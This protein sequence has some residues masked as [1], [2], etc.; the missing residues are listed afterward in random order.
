ML[1][2]LYQKSELW[3]A[4]SWIF[5]YVIGGSLSD[6]ISEKMGAPKL[7]T[8]LF[9]AGLSAVAFVWL[10]KNDLFEK[11]GLCRSAIPARRLLYYLPLAA[12]ASC[13][14]WLG[15]RVNAPAG[16]AVAYVGSMLL[17]GFLEEIIFRGFLFKAMA[18]DGLRPAIIVS[19]VTFGM[20][21]IV[22]LVNGSGAQLLPNLC[23]VGYAIAFGFLFVLLFYKTG[24]LLACIAAHS[25]TNMLSV[26]ANEAARTDGNTILISLVIAAIA[27]LYTAYL[28]KT[29][30]RRA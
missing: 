20:G 7:L 8:L 6:V 19:S 30:P 23:Q 3:F 17:V 9:Y 16:E 13:N 27:I 5:V 18:K 22:N 29:L 2:R 11:Y 4:L 25:V 15:V 28:Q 10:R 21:H 26:F 24:S 14:L 12:A 1:H